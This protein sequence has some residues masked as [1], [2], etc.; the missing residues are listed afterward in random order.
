MRG[1]L[2]GNWSISKELDKIYGGKKGKRTLGIRDKQILYERAKGRCEACSKKIEFSE[3][4]VGHKK[5][6]SK[7]GK[8]TW[9]NSVCLCH[10][11]NKLQGTD[12][13]ET[14]MK[15]MGKIN[16]KTVTSTTKKVKKIKKSKRHSRRSSGIFGPQII[17]LPKLY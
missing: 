14:F 10:T 15:K 4:E 6:A 16:T 17:K 9:K 3:M 12:S 13:W 11:H 8:A 2:T 1:G 5:A 7:G